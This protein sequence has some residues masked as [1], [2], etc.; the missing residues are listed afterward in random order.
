MTIEQTSPNPG[1]VFSAIWAYQ[2]TRAIEAAIR[3]DLFGA[4]GEGAATAE[5][6]AKRIAASEKGTRVLCDF[7]T[8]HGFLLKENEAYTLHPE[9][10][11]FLDSNS[12]AYL[13]GAVQFLLSPT[14]MGSFDN[15]TEVVRQGGTL[16]AGEGTVE[17]DHPVWVEFAK[18]MAPLMMHPA[19][20]MAELVDVPRNGSCRILDVAAGHGLFG[21]AFAKRYPSVEVVAVDWPNVLKVAKE[22]AREAGVDSRHHLME[23]DAFTTNWGNGYK[24]I[25]ATNFFHHFDLAT[26][27]KLMSKMYASLNPGGRVVTLEFIPNPDR[28]TPG[29]TAEFGLTMLGTTG[30]GDAY[31]F[32]AAGNCQPQGPVIGEP[33]IGN[34]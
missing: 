6:V 3:L 27:R 29:P 8:I 17:P 19:Q 18:N 5:E 25:L 9:T 28:V 16:M 2:Q 26:C 22:N 21:I 20:F 15:L 14:I 23:G 31:T 7:L 30:N 32:P 1:K 34:R 10:A 4:I 11:P 24:L 33:V 12:P 13:G